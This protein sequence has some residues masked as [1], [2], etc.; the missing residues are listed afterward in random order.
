MTRLTSKFLLLAL[1]KVPEDER[2]NTQRRFVNA[3]SF[4]RDTALHIAA[5]AGYEATVK[6][7]IS[8]GADVNVRTDTRSTPLHLAA[9][10]GQIA[11]VKFLILH[12]AKLNATDDEQMTPL[13]R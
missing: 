13:H 2:E 6:T 4:E 8:I 11:V 5:Q 1:S 10:S 7:L 3:I 9:I 12:H